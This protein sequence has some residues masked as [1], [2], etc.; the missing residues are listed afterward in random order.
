MGYAAP[1]PG[2]G[3][4]TAGP[5]RPPGPLTEHLMAPIDYRKLR[6]LLGQRAQLVEVLPAGEYAEMHLPGAVNIPL[7]T[8]DGATTAGRRLLLGY[9]LRPQPRAAC[10]LATLG[11]TEVR[12]GGLARPQPRGAGHRRQRTRG[13]RA[14]PHRRLAAPFCAC[15]H[16]GDHA[17]RP[18]TS[19]H[20]RQQSS[21][22]QMATYSVQSISL[23]CPDR[24]NTGTRD[25]P[26]PRAWRLNTLSEVS[27]RHILW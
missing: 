2:C 21:P 5:G 3:P 6:R 7:K 23:T 1:R 14:R 11:F 16:R 27:S 17:A 24:G 4:A 19:H 12:Q 26:A 22:T 13:R 20:P 10:R 15:H 18:A 8:L 9:P 25:R